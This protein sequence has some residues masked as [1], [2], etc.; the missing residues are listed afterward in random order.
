MQNILLIYLVSAFLPFLFPRQLKKVIPFF[1]AFQR[2]CNVEY[3][4]AQ[5]ISLTFH[6]IVSNRDDLGGAKKGI[7][8]RK[9]VV[10]ERDGT[11][12]GESDERVETDR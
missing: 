8:G 6:D 10:L 4:A 11:N 5:V 3:P 7:M 1:L 12:R 2:I 9:W